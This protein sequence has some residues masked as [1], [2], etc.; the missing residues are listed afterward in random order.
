MSSIRF[1]KYIIAFI[2][3]AALFRCNSDSPPEDLPHQGV[4][5][6]EILYSPEPF[7]DYSIPESYPPLPIPEDNPLTVDGVELG[8]MLFYDPILSADSSMS[9]ASCHLAQSSFTD[10]LAVST[11]IDGI[12]GR[13]SAMSLL[14]VAYVT[15]GLFWDGR[16]KTL[17][18]QALIPVEDPIE[19]HHEWSTLINQLR[20]HEFYPTAFRKAFGI[21]NTD[22]INKE[23]AAKA[24]AQFERIILSTGE[25]KYDRYL[26]DEYIPTFDEYNGL[27][28]YFNHDGVFSDETIPDAECS[29]CHAAPLFFANDFMNN[30]ITPVDSS[31]EYPDYGRAKV[32]GLFFDRG[33]FRVPSLRNVVYSAPYMHAGQMETLEEVLDHYVS[34]GHQSATTDAL[35]SQIDLSEQ[36]KR[37]IIAFIEMLVDTAALN[38]PIL[39]N[40]FP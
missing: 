19:M 20:K 36:Q 21:D 34:G 26:K 8:R 18:D 11:G 32:T 31:L 29:H 37:E 40:P 12:A 10:N 35:M 16:V 13:R 15:S 38:R 27:R 25:S 9:C 3:I 30:A 24:I 14:D 23:L 33:K 6:S 2:S 22:Q 1:I 7:T 4:D 39:Q 28:M 17:E 5:L